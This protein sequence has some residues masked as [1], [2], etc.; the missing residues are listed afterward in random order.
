MA[1]L[2]L[3]AAPGV[4]STSRRFT[5]VTGVAESVDATSGVPTTF[6]ISFAPATLNAKCSTTCVPDVTTTF[7]S[8]CLKPGPTT[9]TAY[10]PRGTEANVKLPLASEVVVADQSEVLAFTITI[11]SATG[12]CCGS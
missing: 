8:D 12:R 10:S 7:C 9:V 11:A 6:T 1:R 3:R 4:R 2:L 5:R